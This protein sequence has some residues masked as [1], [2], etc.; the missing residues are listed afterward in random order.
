MNKFSEKPMEA[1]LHQK[2]GKL[3]PDPLRVAS[4]RAEIAYLEAQVAHLREQQR[5]AQEHLKVLSEEQ[6]E[7][8]QTLRT[9]R[10]RLAALDVLAQEAG[11]HIPDPVAEDERRKL[12]VRLE[13]RPVSL[14]AALESDIKRLDAEA[15]ELDERVALSKHQLAEE[16]EIQ[17]QFNQERLDMAVDAVRK[18]VASPRDQQLVTEAKA[19]PEQR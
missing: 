8:M 15:Q 14:A 2:L 16:E 11:G 6:T 4:R 17:N 10:A 19:W 18:G 9:D 5:R 1:T 3:R 7:Q 12:R 13:E